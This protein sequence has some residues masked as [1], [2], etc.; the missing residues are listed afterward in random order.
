MIKNS[1]QASVSK[2]TREELLRA[3]EQ[4]PPGK[5]SSYLELAEEIGHDIEEY[6]AIQTGRLNCFEV[7]GFDS[8]GEALVKARLARGWTHRQLAEALQVSE[9]MVQ[10][11]ETNLYERAGLARVAE[12]ADVLGYDLAG[13]LR[14]VYLPTQMWQPA[15]TPV[16]MNVN[17]GIFVP[18]LTWAPQPLA[19]QHGLTSAANIGI[20]SV[21]YG[22]VLAPA[23]AAHLVGGNTSSILSTLGFMDL[24]LPTG[25]FD[26]SATAQLELTGGNP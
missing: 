4:A 5:R 20:L 18:G 9:Q 23:P 8:L 25:T 14:P 26:S 11:D 24:G 2:K 6:E 7:G 16:A 13:S 15:L 22:N 3:A 1:R 17:V 12:V 10:R 21:S 19:R